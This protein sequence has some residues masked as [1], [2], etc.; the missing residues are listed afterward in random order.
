[1]VNTEKEKKKTAKS[2]TGTASK[3]KVAKI[4]LKPAQPKVVKPIKTP[5]KKTIK[6]QGKY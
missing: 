4:N 1:M 6:S 5:K 3:S 2:T